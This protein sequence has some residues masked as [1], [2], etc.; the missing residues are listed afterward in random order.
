M[1]RAARAMTPVEGMGEIP[2]AIPVQV[3]EAVSGFSK[4]PLNWGSMRGWGRGG[5]LPFP[6]DPLI[7]VMRY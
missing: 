1:G 4:L 6:P 2:G 7:F 3:V 5:T